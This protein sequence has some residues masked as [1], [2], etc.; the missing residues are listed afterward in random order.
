MTVLNI[1]LIDPRAKSL[2]EELAK[3]NLIRIQEE[4]NTPLAAI[5]ERIRERAKKDP[6]SDEEIIEEVEKVRS[7]QY[8]KSASYYPTP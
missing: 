1:E 2:L 7:E 8:K 4:A 6:I 3:L 5:V